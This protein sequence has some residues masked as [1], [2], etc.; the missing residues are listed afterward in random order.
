MNYDLLLAE[1]TG[2]KFDLNTRVAI[3]RLYMFHFIQFPELQLW[4]FGS[5]VVIF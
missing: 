5:V 1:E 4:M 3:I 2:M